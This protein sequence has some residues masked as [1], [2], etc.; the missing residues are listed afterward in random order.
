MTSD[1]IQAVMTRVKTLL[2]ACARARHGDVSRAVMSR[3]EHD[4]TWRAS[5][6]L[7]IK[8]NLHQQT[9]VRTLSHWNPRSTFRTSS[10]T[11]TYLTVGGPFRT[12]RSS[13]VLTQVLSVYDLELWYE[14]RS[15]ST[16]ITGEKNSLRNCSST[17]IKLGSQTNFSIA[18]EFLFGYILYKNCRI[19]GVET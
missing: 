10:S 17:N 3:D 14:R 11:S 16:T 4:C 2:E 1:V 19:L 9:E 5:Q 8:G 7:P 15:S 6:G 13:T 12:L 18:S